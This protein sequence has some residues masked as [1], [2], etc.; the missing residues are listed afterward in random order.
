MN[1]NQKIKNAALYMAKGLSI[2]VPI[3]ELDER[4]VAFTNIVDECLQDAFQQGYEQACVQNQFSDYE[5]LVKINSDLHKQLD[6]VVKAFEQERMWL[7]K[8]AAD[9]VQ[10]IEVLKQEHQHEFDMM[11]KVIR[12]Y[13]D[14]MHFIVKT[15]DSCNSNPIE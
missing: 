1:E 15:I 2:S 14:R 3:K 10:E 5:D 12:D 8:N 6:S 7:H 11:Q 13:R 4:I 9:L